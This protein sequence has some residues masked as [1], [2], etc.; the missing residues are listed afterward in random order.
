MELFKITCVTCRA[1]LSVRDAALVGQIIGCPR[2][3]MMVQVTPSAAASSVG[4]AAIAAA[5]TKIPAALPTPPPAATFED[6]SQAAHASPAMPPPPSEAPAFED[7]AEVVLPEPVAESAAPAAQIATATKG[8]GAYKFPALIAAGAIAGSAMVALGLTWFGEKPTVAATSSNVASPVEPP[9]NPDEPAKS[10]A[11]AEDHQRPSIDAQTS[12]ANADVEESLLP[13]E[14]PG[15]S[16]TP[17]EPQPE[18]PPRVET[19]KEVEAAIESPAEGA[20]TEIVAEKPNIEPAAEPRLRIDPLDV[21]PE[22]LDLTTIFSG[23][24]KDPLAASQ[25]PKEE[26]PAP[27][28][29]PAAPPVAAPAE[30]R[31]V[32]RDE[33]GDVGAP[34]AVEA[35]VA[36]KLPAVSVKK[37]P[38][39]RLL[40]LSSQLSGLPVSVAPAELRMAAVSAATPASVDANDATIEQLLT[41]ALQPLRLQPVIEGEHVLLKWKGDDARRAVDYPVDDLAS[42]AERVKQLGKWVTLLAAPEAWRDAGGDATMTI[43][44]SELRVEAPVPVQYEVLFLLERYRLTR[45]LPT[46]TK[47]P[48]NLLVGGSFHQAV[49]ERMSAPALFTFSQYAPI[50]EVFRFWQEETE[51]AVLVDWPALAEERVWPQTRIA[52]S[53]ADK[54]WAEAMDAVLEPMGLAWRAVDRRAIEITT[55][56]KVDS[57][58][59]LECYRLKADAAAS[60]DQVMKHIEALAGDG[61]GAHAVFY[62]AESRTLLIRLPAAAHRRIVSELGDHLEYSP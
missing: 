3:G 55:R 28:A 7:A 22:G 23:R 33:R 25:L 60:G 5:P 4:A 20:P 14:E 54:P 57:A 45:G 12:P 43:D 40:D 51:V 41:A 48:S 47:Y 8:W 32:H 2:C 16:Q 53:A 46:R 6:L 29:V 61:G 42:T 1:R 31:A 39:C 62:D 9:A 21:D 27:S 34:S 11:P 38:L 36:R 50:R 59:M 26:E 18:A 10:E 13:L 24:Q 30:P 52:C 17:Q 19:P 15:L 37:M 58:S 44:G 49:A 35:L 56:A